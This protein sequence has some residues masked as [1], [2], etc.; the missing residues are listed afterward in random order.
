MRLGS[1]TIWLALLG[2][3]GCFVSVPPLIGGVQ[4]LEEEVVLGRHG[5]KIAM[6]EIEGLISESATRGA[7]GAQRPSMLATA[8][9]VLDLAA[10]DGDVVALLVRVHSP[11]GTPSASDTLHHEI[12]RFQT[13]TGH[14]VV[15]FLQGM[16]TSGGYYVAVASDHIIADP[17]VTTGSIG[18]IMVSL[19][20]AGLMEKLGVA[21]QSVVSGPYK[22]TGSMLRDMREDERAQL[23]G[24]VD[25]LA[26]R[27]REVVAEGRSGL[28]GKA[29][30]ALADGRVFTARQALDHGLIDSVGYLEDAV[31]YLEQQLGIEES[32]VVV[33]HRPGALRTNVYTLPPSAP[34]VDVDVLS[35]GDLLLPPGPYYLWPA[36][37]GLD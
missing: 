2:A 26:A 6:L 33:Y 29:V 19:N 24:V 10:E 23:Q 25:Q 22:D 12:E 1:W 32:R 21:D 27:F 5:P 34:L 18:V 8:R 37:F 11:G 36:P 14:P 16:A 13:E 20:L 4:S 35:L 7:L 28:D 3:P 31:A 17:T 9:E 30:A 15:A